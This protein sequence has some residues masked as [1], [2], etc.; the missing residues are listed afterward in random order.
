MIKIFLLSFPF[1]ASEG[2]YC[3]H[4]LKFDVRPMFVVCCS[5]VVSFALGSLFGPV[6][7][8]KLTQNVRQNGSSF[9]VFLA[10]RTLFLDQ[11]KLSN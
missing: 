8:V 9:G 11:L 10:K 5:F 2:G 7:V 1:V 4:D 6:K 3:A